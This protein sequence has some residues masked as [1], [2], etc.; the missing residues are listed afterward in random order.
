MASTLGIFTL[1]QSAVSNRFA[2]GNDLPKTAAG[3]PAAHFANYWINKHARYRDANLLRMTARHIAS[4]AA[5]AATQLV[6]QFASRRLLAD[7]GTAWH[8]VHSG[9]TGPTHHFVLAIVGAC[10]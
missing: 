9:I 5:P 8:A 3:K 7:S 1:T 2:V 6:W 10:R 4:L